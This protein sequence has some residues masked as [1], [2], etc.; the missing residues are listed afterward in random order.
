MAPIALKKLTALQ[1]A[2]EAEI[3]SIRTRLLAKQRD[4]LNKSMVQARLDAVKQIWVETR[5]THSEIVVRD[6]AETD[7]YI[8]DQWFDRIQ[9]VYESALDEI[10]TLLALFDKPDADDSASMGESDSDPEV[11]KL[12]KISLPTFSGNGEDWASFS[13]LFTSLVHSRSGISDVTKLQ[14][15]KLCLTGVAA[16]L[17]KDVMTTNANYA[18]T[19]QTLKDRY[20]NPRL[21]INKLLTSFLEIPQMK[22]E[23][24]A[25]MRAFADEAKRIVRALTNLKLPVDH[26][27]IWFVFL[28]SDRLDPESRKLWEAKLSEKDQEYVPEAD[29]P[30]RDINSALPK[31]SDL[32]K[33][34]ERRAQALKMYPSERKAEKRSASTPTSG[35]Q[36][37]KVFHARSSRLSGN[38]NCVLCNGTHPLS[39]CFKLKDKNPHERLATVKQ[40]QRCFNCLGSHRANACNSSGRCSTCQGKH[41]TLLHLKFQGNSQA[42]HQNTDNSQAGGSGSK[43]VVSLHAAGVTFPKRR[44][45]LATAKVQIIGPRG[46]STFVRALLDQGSE[47]SFVSESIVQLLGL[48]KEHTCVPLTGLGASAAGTARSRT[49]LVLKSRV[50][51]IFQITTE[52]LILPRLTS[53]LPVDSIEDLD[54]MQFAGLTLADPEFFLSNKVDVI[55]G[56]DVYGQL[57]RSGLRRIPSSQLV[58]QDTAFCWIMSGVLPAKDSRRAESHTSTPLQVLH[59]ASMQELDQMLQRFWAFDE[60]PS[61]F[62]KLKPEDEA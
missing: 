55:L 36:P 45:V 22:K 23:S 17:I 49:Q 32:L 37:R 29:E 43:S 57:L 11:V 60:L 46:D 34:L 38:S 12:P 25:E 35:P 54:L 15:L 24:A 9:G 4:S 16:E 50:D 26:W 5:K 6:D 1:T 13:D 51:T 3:E 31:F 39:K 62:S 27:D 40:L 47:A 19:W 61:S 42:G 7:A 53:Q 21:M 41:H 33:F 44:I 8:T 56:A 20:S 14:Y 28:L 2:R 58:A 52:A 18:S 30:E 59:C 10:L 48:R